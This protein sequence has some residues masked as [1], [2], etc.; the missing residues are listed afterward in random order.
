M[1]PPQRSA[2]VGTD[3]ELSDLLDF[4]AMFS[5]PVSGGRNRRTSLGSSR[6]TAAG[7]DE[8]GTPT[9]TPRGPASPENQPPRVRQPVE[10]HHNASQH[11]TTQHNTTH[12][13][14]T[15]R[16]TTQRI[17]TQ[18]NA[19]HRSTTPTV[20]ELT[21]W[22][23]VGGASPLPACMHTPPP[24]PAHHVPRTTTSRRATRADGW[25]PLHIFLLGSGV[26]LPSAALIEMNGGG[27][28]ARRA[29]PG[30]LITAIS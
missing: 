3:K 23:V 27:V 12:R 30:V 7:M 4:S 1:D 5:P 6:F 19:T 15:H 2:A 22:P 14:T 25:L 8:G 16:N 29:S 20:K 10:A 24:P 17:V 26:P 9:W 18:R 11:Y 13:N 21:M 28:A